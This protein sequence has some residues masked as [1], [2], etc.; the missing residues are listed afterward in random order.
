MSN[1]SKTLSSFLVQ[2]DDLNF[3]FEMSSCSSD[4][5]GSRLGC[6]LCHY[7]DANDVTPISECTLTLI[8]LDSY[9]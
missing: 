7:D 6:C 8:M 9:D 5:R 4:T 1:A 2:Y 3:V